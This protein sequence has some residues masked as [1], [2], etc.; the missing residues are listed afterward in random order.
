[1]ID[2]GILK[3][4]VV[5]GLAATPVFSMGQRN[6]PTLNP[7]PSPMNPQAPQNANV[8]LNQPGYPTQTGS[9]APMSTSMRDSLGAP[10]QTGQQMMDRQFLMATTAGNI[11][12]V[13]ISELAV[14]KGSPAVQD[15]AKK[16]IE[17]HQ[18]INKGFGDVA[19]SMGAR[20]ARKMGREQQAEYDKLNHL[21]G[22]DFDTEYVIYMQQAHFNDLRSFY[23]EGTVAANDDL[24][25]QILE[26]RKTIHD[27]LG[28]IRDTA[29]NEGIALPPPPRRTPRP[30][31]A[32]R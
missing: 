7:N 31:S 20:V 13:K 10:G 4:I 22:K 27:H 30:E 15:L 11:G 26:A 21:S 32:A 3:F 19:D 6:D 23:R 1:M 17:D 5:A 14:Q 25:Q 12:D 16:M 18:N 9:Q 8:P 29:N 24:R 28:L 2:R